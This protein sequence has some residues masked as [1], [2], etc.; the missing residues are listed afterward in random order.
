MLESININNI[1]KPPLS[2]R[3]HWTVYP[4]ENIENIEEDEVAKKE[5]LW[6]DFNR[7]LNLMPNKSGSSVLDQCKVL[8]KQN[9]QWNT[10]DNDKTNQSSTNP[11]VYRSLAKWPQK[12]CG[13][14]Y[15]MNYNCFSVDR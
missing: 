14:L 6:S 7:R 5:S 2:S 3:K 12:K 13:H 8:Q 1:Q 11:P 10:V 15:S 9:P 4:P